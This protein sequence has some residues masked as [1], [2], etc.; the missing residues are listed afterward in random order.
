MKKV[1]PFGH[2]SQQ[3]A[4]CGGFT[5][6]WYPTTLTKSTA[7]AKH[8]VLELVRGLHQVDGLD[9]ALGFNLLINRV[10]VKLQIDVG[11]EIKHLFEGNHVIGVGW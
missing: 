8:L 4:I 10:T 2:H 7:P 3:Q 9:A 5:R 1:L 6:G 11:T